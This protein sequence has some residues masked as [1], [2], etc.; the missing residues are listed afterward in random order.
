MTE[1]QFVE[2]RTTIGIIGTGSMGS[3]LVKGW[4]RGEGAGIDLLVWDEVEAATRALPDSARLAVAE[5]LDDLTARVDVVVIVVK[6]KDASQVFRSLAGQLGE[7][8]AVVSSMAGVTLETMRAALGPGP[9]LFRIMPNLGVELGVGTVALAAEVGT[10]PSDVASVATLLEPL[11]HVE[12]VSEELLDVVTALS[13]SG[14]AFLALAME[15]LED[16]AVAAGLSRT[17]ARIMVRGAA[18]QVAGLLS[19][20]GESPGRLREGLLDAG[21]PEWAALDIVEDR[22]VRATFQRAVEAA[23][24][25]SRRLREGGQ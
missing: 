25:R 23:Y 15:G 8:R 20:Q 4:L 11:G 7:G 1:G 17:A 24:D 19:D 14:P 18:L 21:G 13:G 9:P 5:S 10:P 3:A 12:I 16:G 2:P 6:P 22:H